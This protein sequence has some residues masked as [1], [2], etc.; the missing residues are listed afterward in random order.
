MQQRQPYRSHNVPKTHNKQNK[1]GLAYER[2]HERKVETPSLA[3][4]DPVPRAQIPLKL[5]PADSP[6]TS[7]LYF[8]CA[9]FLPRSGILVALRASCIQRF[10]APS[11]T[12]RAVLEFRD[13]SK[14]FLKQIA[15][16]S[17]RALYTHRYMNM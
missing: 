4:V 17:L 9:G 6:R 12:L 2:N 5:D 13:G 10:P 11:Q 3:P 7:S 16:H 14:T 1:I 8:K 15:P